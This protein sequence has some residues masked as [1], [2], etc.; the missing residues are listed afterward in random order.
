[1]VGLFIKLKIKNKCVICFE[2]LKSTCFIFLSKN[3][4]I[5]F[6]FFNRVKK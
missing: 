6:N 2:N 1:M 4:C 3:D 5:N